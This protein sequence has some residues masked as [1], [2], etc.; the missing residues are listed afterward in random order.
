[1]SWEIYGTRIN[2]CERNLVTFVIFSS[3]DHLLLT[4]SEKKV[5][6]LFFF[7]KRFPFLSNPKYLQFA[8]VH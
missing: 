5:F 2:C 4:Y 8:T 1:M 7:T 6:S 3:Y